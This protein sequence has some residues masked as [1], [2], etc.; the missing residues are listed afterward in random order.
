MNGTE[1]CLGTW[2]RQN[3]LNEQEKSVIDN[4]LINE[5][6]YNHINYMEIDEENTFCPLRTTK[7]KNG[8]KTSY[9]DH[10]SVVIY[11]KLKKE[12]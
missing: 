5:G 3:N 4:I 6:L 7:L 8:I 1:K 2:S 10:N 12:M 11:F 9:S